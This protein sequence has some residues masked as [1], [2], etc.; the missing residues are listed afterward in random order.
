MG[1]PFIAIHRRH[2]PDH[3]RKVRRLFD[4][5]AYH[6][7]TLD[8][9][10]DQLANEGIVYT[11]ACP[12]FPR[13]KL[14]SILK[15]RASLGEVMYQDNWYAGG[16]APLVDLATFQRLQVLLGGQLYRS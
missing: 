10:Q 15:D 14:Y 8:S 1:R 4:L 7:H 6:G 13:S 11:D 12:R 3:G 2:D 16:H 5:Y 9:L